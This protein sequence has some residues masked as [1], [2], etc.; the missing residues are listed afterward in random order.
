MNLFLHAG[1]FDTK[2]SY[3]LLTSE[4]LSFEQSAKWT[5][6]RKLK[7]NVLNI[8]FASLLTNLAKARRGLQVSTACPVCRAYV[9]LN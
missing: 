5:K 4:N 7:L 1:E 2:Y 8:F 9:E 3:S 6:I